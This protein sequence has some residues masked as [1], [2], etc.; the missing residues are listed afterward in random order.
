MPAYTDINRAIER[1]V[2]NGKPGSQ[3]NL[4]PSLKVGRLV[5]CES[6]LEAH[7]CLSLE[8]EPTVASYLPQPEQVHIDCPTGRFRYT[9]DF[10]VIGIE[11]DCYLAEIKPDHILDNKPYQKKLG[12]I[13]RHYDGQGKD[14]R[15]ILERD[16]RVNPRI[17][18]LEILHGLVKA[19]KPEQV[20]ALIAALESLNGTA[21]IQSIHTACRA[22]MLPAIA[23]GHLAGRVLVDHL[24]PLSVQ[25]IISLADA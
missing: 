8:Y 15:L 1:R 13:Q 7:F 3:T 16:I 24:T 6:A 23:A 19:A 21:T 4:F 11:G 17:E 10:E 25:S 14:F 9:P 18:N 2:L 12:H 5:A 22:D 20:T